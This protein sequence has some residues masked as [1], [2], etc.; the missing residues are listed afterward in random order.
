MSIT[1]QE[2]LPQVCLQAK[3]VEAF[4]L[5]GDSGCAQLMKAATVTTVTS[6][7]HRFFIPCEVEI[8]PFCNRNPCC[9]LQPPRVRAN[10]R[11]LSMRTS[12]HPGYDPLQPVSSSQA[13]PPSFP[14]PEETAQW[15]ENTSQTG[16]HSARELERAPTLSPPPRAWTQGLQ[17]CVTLYPR[18]S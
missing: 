5:P 1:N 13:L 14:C 16:V 12:R 9:G 2:N 4:S 6:S 18:H 11:L 8:L 17:G 10:I 3:L 7:R 15:A